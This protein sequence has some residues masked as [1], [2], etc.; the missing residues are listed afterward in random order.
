MAQAAIRIADANKLVGKDRIVEVVER[1]KNGKFKSFTKYLVEKN[2]QNEEI[3]SLVNNLGNV[4]KSLEALTA[5]NAVLGAANLCA[6]VAGFAIMNEKLNEVNSN[7]EDVIDIIQ[8]QYSIDL[9]EDFTKIKNDYDFILDEKRHNNPIG[10]K[11]FVEKINN[12]HALLQKLIE[13]FCIY[14][15][16]SNNEAILLMILA[17]SSMMCESIKYFNEEYFEEYSNENDINKKLYSIDEWMKDYD[18]INSKQF[19]NRIYELYFIDKGLNQT[20]ANTSIFEIENMI[21]EH[22]QSIYDA[23]EMLKYSNDPEEFKKM[24]KEID[25]FVIERMNDELKKSSYSSEIQN[26]VLQATKDMQLSVA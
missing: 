10:R 9:K 5:L 21:N 15:T 3:K 1:Y 18:A 2:P 19:I 26:D 14:K 6:T 8:N 12:Q 22:V 11:D 4:T 17:L 20:E 16:Q 24:L 23:I 13:C 25:A 7:I